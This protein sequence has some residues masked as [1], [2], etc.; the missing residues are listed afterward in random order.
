MISC[1]QRCNFFQKTIVEKS[2][3]FR[4]NT[5]IVSK[6]QAQKAQSFP[7]KKR[8]MFIAEDEDFYFVK[9]SSKICEKQSQ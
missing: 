1:Q 9:T 6:K 8:L 2:K 7:S 5:E 4:T 3:N